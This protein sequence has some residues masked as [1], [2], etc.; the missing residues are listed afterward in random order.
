M[1]YSQLIIGGLIGL[2]WFM[3]LMTNIYFHLSLE[4]LV[5]LGFGYIGVAGL[6]W[7]PRWLLYVCMWGEGVL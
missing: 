4:K 7:I 5:G 6:Y 2:W 3:L 1:E